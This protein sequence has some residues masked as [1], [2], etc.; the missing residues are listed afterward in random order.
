MPAEGV[1]QMKI[2]APATEP[3]SLEETGVAL[4]G[5]SRRYPPRRRKA[6]AVTALES[7]DLEVR[8]GRVLGVVGPSG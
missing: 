6:P 1:M 5:V 7:I 2:E 8:S 4:S 3:L